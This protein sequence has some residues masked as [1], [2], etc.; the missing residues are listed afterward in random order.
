MA[1]NDLHGANSC[2]RCFNLYSRV[3]LGVACLSY[4][5]GISP[6]GV[7]EFERRAG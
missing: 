3:S 5:L 1:G 2:G 7:A 4:N 6:R